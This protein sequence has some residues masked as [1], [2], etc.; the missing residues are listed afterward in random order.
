MDAKTQKAVIIG[1]SVAIVA[2]LIVDEIRKFRN[3]G[4]LS[5]P[6]NTDHS[7]VNWV[8]DDDFFEIEGDR[9][10]NGNPHMSLT[11]LTSKDAMLNFPKFKKYKPFVVSPS[12]KIKFV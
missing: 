4:K 5:T 7:F 9:T 11:P 8:G 12:K 10:V 3:K 1:L 2:P 6:A